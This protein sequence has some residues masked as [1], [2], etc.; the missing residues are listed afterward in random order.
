[1]GAARQSEGP[2]E[3]ACCEAAAPID[4]C[5]DGTAPLVGGGRDRVGTEGARCCHLGSGEGGRWP[6]NV[7][8]SG[9]LGRALLGNWAK[10][11]AHACDGLATGSGGK[12]A[13][14]PTLTIHPCPPIPFD[15]YGWPFTWSGHCHSLATHG[16]PS[17]CPASHWATPARE[18]AERPE[19]PKP[20]WPGAGG[21]RAEGRVVDTLL[22]HHQPGPAMA[23]PTPTLPPPQL[24]LP[25]RG[26][27]LALGLGS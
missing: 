25:G 6:T 13:T 10:P 2:G 17:S 3:G 8:P 16:C 4:G 19:V 12:L 24:P 15:A 1:M 20:W 11:A 22:R 27:H 23:L 21:G 7:G 26:Q 14:S 18:P 9:G 5:R